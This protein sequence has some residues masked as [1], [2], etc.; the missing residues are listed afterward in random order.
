[1]FAQLSLVKGNLLRLV[2]KVGLQKR[3]S[4]YKTNPSFANQI[5]SN[6]HSLGQV[7][8]RQWGAVVM[9]AVLVTAAATI[10]VFTLGPVYEAKALI[11]I[12]AIGMTFGKDRVTIKNASANY[13]QAQYVFLQ[14]ASLAEK[15][16]AKLN[17]TEHSEFSQGN[18]VS[19]VRN[20]L[21]V[22]PIKHSQLV[23][24]FAKSQDA[25]LA[26]DLANT[27]V[28]FYI[29]ENREANFHLSRKMLNAFHSVKSDISFENL[30]MVINNKLVQELKLRLAELEGRYAEMKKEYPASHQKMQQLTAH[31][32]SMREHINTAIR[33]I[34]ESIQIQLS[35]PFE[36]PNVQIVKAARPPTSPIEPQ[37]LKVISLA[38]LIGL[39]GGLSIAYLHDRRIHRNKTIGVLKR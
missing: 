9:F 7:I 6:L 26:A 27:L 12:A 23:S 10:T 34:I 17:L 32:N 4:F 13:Y 2:N 20:C 15:V 39:I 22:R 16:V 29:V 11:R 36:I 31:I 14:S 24:I 3:K 30:P 33:Q 19:N 38:L 35:G 21:R 37:K 28:E 1:V 18:V 5:G 25:A 8:Q